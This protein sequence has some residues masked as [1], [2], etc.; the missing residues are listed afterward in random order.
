M[1]QKRETPAPSAAEE[2]GPPSPPNYSMPSHTDPV[3]LSKPGDVLARLYPSAALAQR[4]LGKVLLHC[5]VDVSGYLFD[6]TVESE[7]PAHVGFGNAALEATGYMK[8]RP[9]TQYGVPVPSPINIP[10]TFEPH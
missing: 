4:L 3:W 7:T 8:M 2:E 1:P 6:C 10:L 5:T 9:A